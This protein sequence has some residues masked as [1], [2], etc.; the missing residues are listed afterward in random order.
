[1]TEKLN[2]L[3]DSLTNYLGS[4]N[5]IKAGLVIALPQKPEALILTEQ[6]AKLG[7]PLEAGG[8]LDQPHIWLYEYKTVLDIT[9][10]FEQI[11]TL[12]N[13]KE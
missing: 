1:M 9:Q 7:L 6:I 5:E 8:V 10:L 12:R 4:I 2:E 13:I 3:K 11:E